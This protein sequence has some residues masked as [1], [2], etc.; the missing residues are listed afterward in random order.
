MPLVC[1]VHELST[2]P[3]V[4]TVRKLSTVP[5]V[6]T[7]HELCGVPLLC[8]LNALF[9]VPHWLQLPTNTLDDRQLRVLRPLRVGGLG[10]SD[11]RAACNKKGELLSAMLSAMH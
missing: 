10:E 3:L 5:L 1:T 7:T 4:C 11:G 9:T 6:C 2:V 8:T